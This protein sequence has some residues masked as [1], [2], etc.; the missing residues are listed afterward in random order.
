[1]V[2]SCITITP[3]LCIDTIPLVMVSK[4]CSCYNIHGNSYGGEN[5]YANENLSSIMCLCYHYGML[6]YLLV[7][8]VLGILKYVQINITLIKSKTLV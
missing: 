1:M 7:Y 3:H 4:Q 5:Y 2:T 8:L 6:D